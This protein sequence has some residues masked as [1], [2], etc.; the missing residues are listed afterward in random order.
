MK[1]KASQSIVDSKSRTSA[2][3]RTEIPRKLSAICCIRS[4][5]LS[6][7]SQNRNNIAIHGYKCVSHFI[8]F[9]KVQGSRRW[10]FAV[11]EVVGPLHLFLFFYWHLLLVQKIEQI[12]GEH[13]KS[14][15]IPI[16]HYFVLSLL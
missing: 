13:W 4:L 3:I 8:V 2:L 14:E 16:Q 10:K 15:F 12:V 11:A 9:G 6:S 7:R 5:F 1:Q